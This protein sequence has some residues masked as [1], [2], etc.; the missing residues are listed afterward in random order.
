[1]FI[2]YENQNGKVTEKNPERIQT[3]LPLD[4]SNSYPHTFSINLITSSVFNT[5]P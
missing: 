5:L 1:M 2:Y 3:E 4:F